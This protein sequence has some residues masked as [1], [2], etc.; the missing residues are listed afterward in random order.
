MCY[1]EKERPN[2]IKV[3]VDVIVIVVVVWGC[4]V[5]ATFVRGEDGEILKLKYFFFD[6]W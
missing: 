3:V 1:G 5:A 4:V 2:E 6:M